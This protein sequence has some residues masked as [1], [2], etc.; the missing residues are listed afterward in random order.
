MAYTLLLNDKWD[1]HVDD[2]GN[3]A[4]VVDDYAIAQNV[5]NA[6]R[7]FENDAY[8]ERTRGVPY[9]TEVFGEKV[10]VSQSVVI[11]RWR[12]AAMSVTGVTACEPQPVYDNE[13]RIIGGRISATTINGTRVQIEV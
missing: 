5:A 3:I 4:T 12:K 9:L 6:V 13:G 8:F 10:V 1:I 11:N 7:L 2:A